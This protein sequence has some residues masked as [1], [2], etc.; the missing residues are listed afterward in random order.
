MAEISDE[1]RLDIL[2]IYR[3]PR[4]YTLTEQKGNKISVSN[5]ICPESHF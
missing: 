3:N 4:N 5:F 1:I 2:N